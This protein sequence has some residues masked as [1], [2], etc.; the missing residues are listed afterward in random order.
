MKDI[1]FI[2]G[3][4]HLGEENIFNNCYSYFFKSQEEYIETLVKNYNSKIG[5]D[6]VEVCF[7]GDLG[8]KEI[9]QKV[10]PRLKGKKYLILG[11]HD[12]YSTEFYKKYFED[13]FAYPVYINSRIVLSH[14]PIPTEPGIL[15]A[16]GHTHYIDLISDRH[17]NL[18]IE[19]TGFEPYN[20]KNLTK[21]LFNIQKPNRKFLN[22]WFKDIQR[23]NTKTLIPSYVVVDENN[24]L[25]VENTRKKW[26]LKK[27]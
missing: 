27:G 2:V 26:V 24:K 17:I 14:E 23:V 9:I 20:V 6:N 21:M 7:L 4:L 1:R 22:E 12:K 13:V 15:N 25:D 19:K 8:R 16:H 11:N 3:D 18:V 5:S 10:L